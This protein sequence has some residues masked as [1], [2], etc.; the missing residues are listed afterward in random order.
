VDNLTGGYL[1][2]ALWFASLDSLNMKRL[3]WTGQT[4][5]TYCPPV[6]RNIMDNL[7]EKCPWEN[8]D[9]DGNKM[10]GMIL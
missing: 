3:Q 4:V 5:R 9:E 1:Q 10:L 8:S 6:P 7:E 2:T